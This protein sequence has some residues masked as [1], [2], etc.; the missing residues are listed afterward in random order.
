MKFYNPRGRKKFVNLQTTLNLIAS[1]KSNGPYTR[2][3]YLWY[4]GSSEGSG[5]CV[6]MHRLTRAIY[7]R[8]HKV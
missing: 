6:H 4:W 5:E 7:A 8:I 3:W 2:L 1:I